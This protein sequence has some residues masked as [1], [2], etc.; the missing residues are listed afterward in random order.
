MHRYFYHRHRL[1]RSDFFDAGEWRHRRLRSHLVLGGALVAFGLA[2]LLRGWGVIGTEGLWLAAP[3]VLAWSGLVRIALD[4]GA[5]SIVRATLRFAVAAYLVVVIEQLGG[6][7]W[8]STWP[9]LAIA[10]GVATVAGA[11]L[12]RARD[13][14]GEHRD[15]EAAW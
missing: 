5:A 10:V 1:A 4:R 14:D 2:W 7:T 13:G 3:A 6:L 15:E 8:A 12:A 11:F 9:V